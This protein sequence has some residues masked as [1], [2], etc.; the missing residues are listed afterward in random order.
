MVYRAIYSAKKEKNR[1]YDIIY[2][3]INDKKSYYIESYINGK[4]EHEL[5]FL[6]NCTEEKAEALAR[7][8][9]ENAVRPMHIEDII[10]DI[11]F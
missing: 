9:A 8:F 11:R 3:V 6:G 2:C 4:G 7:L 1:N 10:S 5:A